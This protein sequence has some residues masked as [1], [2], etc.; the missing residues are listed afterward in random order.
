MS[1]IPE[2]LS[3]VGLTAVG[4]ALI[5]ARE[6]SRSDRLIVDP[7]AQLFAD[8]AEAEFIGPDAPDGAENS[9]AQMLNLVESF[10]DGRVLATRYFDEYL[11]AA[12]E[13]GCVQVVNVGAGLDTRAL[14]LPLPEHVVCFELDQPAMFAFKERVL[15]THLDGPTSASRRLVV[16]TDLRGAWLADLT[17]AGYDRS[18]PTAW[19]EEGVL[20]YLPPENATAVLDTI[21]EV[22]VAGGRLAKAA[23]PP[24]R[25]ND[26][27]YQRMRTFVGGEG[28]PSAGV[29]GVDRENAYR[30]AD[31]GWRLTVQ[32]H[33]DL[34]TRYGRP[35]SDTRPAANTGEYIS[36]ERV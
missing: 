16:P 22:T 17:A 35:G 34:A 18:R 31:H 3:G 6:T 4:V 19:L 1:G 36:A 7:Y 32:T 12:V 5:R 33:A 23:M 27:T 15:R 2:S 8:A 25:E 10:H 24:P 28:P 13:A 30:L 26:E 14:R 11:L 9:W 21:T 29:T 20:A